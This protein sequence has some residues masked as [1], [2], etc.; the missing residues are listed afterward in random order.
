MQ[1]LADMGISQSVVAWLRV[2]DHDVAHLRDRGLQ[3]LPNGQI[4]QIAAAERRIILTF[5]VDFGE[6]LAHTSD[7]Q[8][9]VILFRLNNTTSP[10]VIKRLK[11][12]LSNASDAL[13]EGAIVL[14][15]DA[16][17]RIRR[18]PLKS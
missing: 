8:V 7:A 4:Y 15:E 16:R 2:R 12:A 6:I 18:L 3:R 17:L 5:D 10:V 1:F 13:S 9:S 14:V 11:I